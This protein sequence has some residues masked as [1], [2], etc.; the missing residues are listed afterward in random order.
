MLARVATRDCCPTGLIKDD[1]DLLP[2]TA[3]IRS[4]DNQGWMIIRCMNPTDTPVWLKAGTVVGTYTGV[5]DP[6]VGGDG[7]QTGSWRFCIDY[8][9]LN[10]MTRHNA[11]PIPQIDIV[12]MLWQRTCSLARSTSQAVT[13]M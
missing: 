5:D 10:D 8:R 11:Y 9:R 13:G 4:P 6:H 7:A 3:C 2:L 1:T 12:W